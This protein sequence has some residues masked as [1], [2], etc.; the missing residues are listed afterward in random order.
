VPDPI[1]ADPRLAAI[2]D[3]IDDDRSDLDEY[4]ALVDELG[5]TSILD[6]GCGTGTLACILAE[7]GRRVA[8]VD[9]AAAS[10][11]VA[12]RKPSADRVRW[13]LGDATSVPPIEVD[14]VAMTGNVAQVFLTDTEWD[15]V[16]H[17]SF[18]AL[19]PGGSLV[20]ETRDPAK[21]AWE[22]WN[23]AATHRQVTTKAEGRV[24]TWVDLVDLAL[25]LVTFRHTYVFEE[26][27]TSTSESTLRFRE[28]EEIEDSLAARSFVV[29]E[30]R[31]APDRP[32][33]EF[34]F[35]ADR[36]PGL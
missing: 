5:A 28:R 1:F 36:P 33:L 4:A 13:L 19:R 32:G 21:R 30:V 18:A 2:Y 22:G 10:L 31:D 34:V 27:T 20:F 29:R 17:A 3:E 6:L 9:P 25:P 16:L 12:K 23:R 7:Q 8:G 24:E 15:S 26:G 35:V 14:L 11:A